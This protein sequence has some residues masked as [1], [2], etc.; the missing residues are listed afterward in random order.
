MIYLFSKL[1]YLPL[2]DTFKNCAITYPQSHNNWHIL[3]WYE[4]DL[5]VFCKQTPF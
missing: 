2:T 5:I 4:W 1:I 3:R